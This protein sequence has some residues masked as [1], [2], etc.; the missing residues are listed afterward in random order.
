MRNSRFLFLGIMMFGCVVGCGHKAEVGAPVAAPTIPAQAEKVVA[1]ETVS[2]LPSTPV[3]VP[4]KKGK[5]YAV[6]GTS[7]RAIQ[8][9]DDR[10]DAY[11]I[12]PKNDEE[13]AFNA[14]LKRSI[15]HGIFDVSELCRQ[16]L[17]KHWATLAEADQK[18]FVDLMTRL[19]EK[20]GIFSKEQDNHKGTDGK[21]FVTYEGDKFLSPEK[22]LSLV[23]THVHIPKENL[24][25][26]LN[27]K[28]RRSAEWKIFD[29]IVDQASL[30]DNYKYQFDKI[31]SKDG[32]PELYKRMSAKLQDME[33]KEKKKT[34]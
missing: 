9:L 13:R 5:K 32:Y 30:L 28:M 3:K 34:E 1:P 22:T 29:V 27:Y 6:E 25:I 20:K 19:L 26:E 17:D 10:I 8:E 16:A 24:S 18:S 21:Y 11:I 12:N 31:I 2:E 7:T 33:A 15:I 14:N 4:Q 23:N